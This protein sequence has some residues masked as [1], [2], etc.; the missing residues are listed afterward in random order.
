MHTNDHH[1][2]PS[3]GSALTNTA[4]SAT[5][6]CLSECWITDPWLNYRVTS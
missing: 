4:I 3:S 5:L 6:H 1:E 2:M